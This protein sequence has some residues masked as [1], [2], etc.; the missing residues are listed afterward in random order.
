MKAP[1][2]QLTPTAMLVGAGV[3][4][5][6]I[7]MAWTARNV[8]SAQELGSEVGGAVVDVADGVF[9]GAVMGVGDVLGV[10]RTDAQKCA[11]AK[12]AGDTWEAGLMCPAGDFLAYLWGGGSDAPAP[13]NTWGREART[14]TY[15]GGA[16][17]SW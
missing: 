9:S 14:P 13:S 12:A 11:A 16:S 2:I 7:A 1:A 10:P 6:I 4:V 17:G 5:A 15:T 8:G 3:G